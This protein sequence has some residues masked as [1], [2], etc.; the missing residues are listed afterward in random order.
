[1][2]DL[3]QLSW[4]LGIQF[5][6]KNNTIKIN[7]SRYIE[8]SSKFGMADCKSRSTPCEMDVT[9]TSDNNRKQTLS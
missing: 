5:E 3:G 2:T 9:K 1:M 7:Q 6:C 8:I 4:F